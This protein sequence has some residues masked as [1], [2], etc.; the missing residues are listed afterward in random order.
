MR[1]LGFVIRFEKEIESDGTQ[2]DVDAVFA[3]IRD[4]TVEDAML[5]FDGVIEISHYSTDE[6]DAFWAWMNGEEP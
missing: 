5:N 4:M 1:K 2:P 6:D 3:I